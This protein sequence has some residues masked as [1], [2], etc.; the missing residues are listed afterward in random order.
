MN[1]GGAAT[2]VPPRSYENVGR[3]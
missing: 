1:G 3:Y 2:A